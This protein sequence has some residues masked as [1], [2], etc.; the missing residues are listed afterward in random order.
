MDEFAGRRIV[1]TGGAAQMSGVSQM[2]EYIFKKRIRV[3]R[4][5]G[6]LDLPNSMAGPDFAVSAGLLKHSLYHK[7]EAV[8]GPPD[9][10]GQRLKD[11]RY[12]GGGVLKSLKWLKENF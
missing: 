11:R 10:S 12:A 6:L 9:L 2:A 5:H 3:G 7:N 1:L 8:S 4:P